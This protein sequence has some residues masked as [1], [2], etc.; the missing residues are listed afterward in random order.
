MHDPSTVAFEIKYPFPEEVNKKTGYVYRRPI[1]TIWHED[2]CTDGTDDS[3]GW[4]LRSRHL[5]QEVLKKIISEFNFNWDRTFECSNGKTISTCWFNPDGSPHFSTIG[6]V[7]DMFTIAAIEALGRKKALKYMRD[8]LPRIINFAE[9]P[10]DSLYDGIHRTFQIACDEPYTPEQREE[11]IKDMA[12]CVYAYIM[13]DVRPW[14]KHPRWHIHHW[15]IQFHP[16]EDLK[17]FLT[18]RCCIC[19]KRIRSRDCVCSGGDPDGKLYHCACDGRSGHEI[20]Q[21][22]VMGV[23]EEK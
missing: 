20:N 15:R 7:V 21:N 1:I 12:K 8:H 18:K 14:Y 16:Y 9:N 5:N 2:P 19:G 17:R 10:T 13:R 11:R 3:C 23:S 4:F 6:I 22:P